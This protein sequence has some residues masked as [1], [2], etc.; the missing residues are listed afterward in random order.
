MR[1]WGA[2]AF[3]SVGVA[4]ATLAIAASA[5]AAT[6][7]T[8]QLSNSKSP[9]A[10][11]TPQTG[12]VPASTAMNFEVTLQLPDQAGAEAFARSVSTPGSGDY[13]QYLTAAQ[14]EARFSPTTADV[15][16][17]KRFLRA[18]GFTVGAVSAD[19]M[20][21]SASGTAAQVE[22]AFGTSLSYHTVDHQQLLLADTNL[23]V[24]TSI[25]GIVDGVSGVSDTLAQPDSTTGGPSPA[26]TANAKPPAGFRNPQPCGKYYG[27]YLAAAFPAV[28]G[29]YPA[30]PPYAPCGY[31]P[32]Q[33][34][35][36]YSVPSA[37]TGAG[38]T[39]AIVDAYAS[40]TILADAQQYAAQNDPAH[41][42]LSSQFSQ[43]LAK[44]F[45]R[46]QACGGQ[47]GWWGEETLDVEAVH[48]MAP[49]ANILYAG[50]KNC[51][52][53][54]LNDMLSA[55]VDNHLADVITNSYGDAGG[56]V[57]DSSDDRQ[58]TDDI[59]MM[60]AATGITVSFSSGDDGD[61]YS[62]IGSVAADYPASSPWATA[63]GGTTLAID[64][65]GQRTSEYGWSTGISVYCN[66]DLVAAGGCDSSD[67]R[68]W[69]PL[70]YDYGSGGGTSF[71][72]AQPWYQQG[73]VPD[74]LADAN[75]S[76]IGPGAMRV[77]PDVSMDADPTTGMLVGETQTFPDGVYYDQYRIGGTSLASPLLAGL[78]ADADQ[79]SGSSLGFL[80]PRLYSLPSSALDDIVAPASPTDII[81]PD[82]IDGVDRASGVE[83]SA[84]A[85]N[86]E[87][88]EEY[89]NPT[90]GQC[91]TRST[92]ALATAPG[93]DNM[94]GLG[95]PGAGFIGAL[96]GH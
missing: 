71:H 15:T 76:I 5:S 80:N 25:A 10:A 1:L 27:Q 32:P 14:W 47:N 4:A 20:S 85:V 34:R 78:V 2:R 33:M 83:Y 22:Q 19:R 63:A 43:L 70:G 82:F 49:D 72:Y 29:G 13:G 73:V 40:P 96:S 64:A 6:S 50:A 54:P 58:A 51:F 26:A 17:V 92:T 16:Q 3:T 59:L 48:A 91:S 46:G 23:S 36:A 38:K 66:A 41:P 61:E 44:N 69:G 7:A 37:D 18:D 21:V 35:S 24:P 9:A 84:R 89:C 68:T 56:D 65:N 93:Y 45:N 62:T 90:S 60:A 75:A 95:T 67:L 57:L 79:A 87:G 88:P 39:V 53:K 8:T 11:Q 30:N 74:S 52:T 77:E 81:R 42:L 55:I 31:T 28:P 12:S 94:T 86:Y